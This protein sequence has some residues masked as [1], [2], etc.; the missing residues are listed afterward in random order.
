MSDFAL[1]YDSSIHYVI[2]PC[3]SADSV[4]HSISLFSKYLVLHSSMGSSPTSRSIFVSHGA[5]PYPVLGDKQHQPL[6]DLLTSNRHLLDGCNGIIIFSAHWETN[7]PHISGEENPGVCYDYDLPEYRKWLPKEAFKFD[8]PFKGNPTLA[9]E[10][11]ATLA[12]VGYTP[13]VDKERGWD[14]ATFV[15]LA[16]LTPKWDI[17]VVQM[18]ILRGSDDEDAT[19]K[20]LALGRAL[21]SFRDR[22]YTFI[23]SGSSSHD[24][25]F[26]EDA[27]RSGE[28]KESGA[29]PFEDTLKS[30]AMI[31][32]P[33]KRGKE[34][35]RWRS[36][37]SN[38][39]AHLMGHS[40]HYMPF[41][42]VAG[43]AGESPGDRFG[44]WDLAGTPQS[45]F[46]WA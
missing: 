43:T 7:E 3:T 18:S 22:G 27:F 26:I 25:K 13:V 42:A 9:H 14:H 23:G 4:A 10:I 11:A 15:P 21:M 24:N 12:E 34:L 41:M 38:I 19:R 6:V 5:G 32:D 39:D 37:P 45:N 29:W 40:D 30:A 36:W 2:V 35:M 17:S 33:V 20:N 8:W 16:H 28:R 44:I 31:A 46:V 1:R